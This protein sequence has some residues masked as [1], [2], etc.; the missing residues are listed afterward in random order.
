MRKGFKVLLMSV[1]MSG[2]FAANSLTAYAGWF[3]ENNNWYY[4]DSANRVYN[5]EWQLINGS[6]YRFDTSSR[7]QK[8]WILDGGKWYFLNEKNGNMLVGWQNINN[9]WYFLN[10]GNGGALSVN[11]IIDGKYY[12]NA[13]GEWKQGGNSSKS[14]L[15][16][17]VIRLVNEER[18]KNGLAALRK[19]EVLMDIAL[20]RA[21][22]LPTSFSHNRPD[23]S[24]CFDLYDEK[25]YVYKSSGENIAYG[26][27]SPQSVM[28][29]WMN[30]SGHRQNILNAEFKEIGVGVYEKDGLYYWVQAF[31]ASR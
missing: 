29:G 1:F 6:W 15:A 24:S 18:S 27:G 26:Q 2:I 23:G 14:T 10:P 19:S 12:V 4:K 9:K 25:G 22:D 16:D 7:M 30:S 11:T 17:E 21:S 28:E 31:G 20:I 3:Q 5:N 13:D 8:G